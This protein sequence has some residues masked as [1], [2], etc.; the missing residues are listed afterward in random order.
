MH[1]QNTVKTFFHSINR[2]L[3]HFFFSQN[4]LAALNKGSGCQATF[5]RLA[6]DWKKNLDKQRYVV[7]LL[8]YPFK[9]FGCLLYD[10]ILAKVYAYMAIP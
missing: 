7:T 1:P 3:K 8:M 5:L 10:R 9:A 2:P 6:E 4:Y